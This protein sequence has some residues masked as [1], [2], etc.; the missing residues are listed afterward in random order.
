MNDSSLLP[1]DVAD[2]SLADEFDDDQEIEPELSDEELEA[3]R[4]EARIAR[5][6]E[7]EHVD[8]FATMVRSLPPGEAVE[9]YRAFFSPL[10][11]RQS[12]LLVRVSLKKV[13]HQAILDAL[14]RIIAARQDIARLLAE[15]W[16]HIYRDVLEIM[17]QG[18][19]PSEH[20]ST[21]VLLTAQFV[22]EDELSDDQEMRALTA[23]LQRAARFQADAAQWQQKHGTAQQEIMRLTR[24]ANQLKEKLKRAEERTE[25]ALRQE[26][27]AA[28]RR[29][30]REKRQAQQTLEA[31]KHALEQQQLKHQ[32]ELAATQRTI[33][34]LEQRARSS[35]NERSQQLSSL[36]AR[37][38]ADS[39]RLRTRH[40]QQLT[41]LNSKML[42]LQQELSA[43]GERSETVFDEALLD[44]ALVISYLTLGAAP[45]QR[46]TTLFELY[47]AFLQNQRE[48]EMLV[49]HSNISQF[50]ERQPDGIL[51]FGL[52]QLLLDGVNIPL[53]RY[54]KM[55]GLPRETILH[56]LINRMESPR[57]REI[58]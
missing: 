11:E 19:A 52:E 13:T 4:L 27:E 43:V 25:T 33:E 14:P 6:L 42:A 38:R 36:L 17:S 41:E 58:R 20:I 5:F 51:L 26:R 46:M 31:S 29:N 50:K 3:A 1:E 39:E 48:D 57:L 47:T 8:Q 12:L 15:C 55:S 10:D 30:E 45:I 53:T 18:L 2:A 37:E 56:Q 22:L 7:P 40:A 54:L 49:Q 21:D 24:E 35:E 34:Y 16:F 32:Q 44:N 9:A 28:E 23:A